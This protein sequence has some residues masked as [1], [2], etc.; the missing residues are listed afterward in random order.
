MGGRKGLYIVGFFVGFLISTSSFTM[1]L[2]EKYADVKVGDWVKLEI[3][4]G[5]TQLIF[6]ADRDEKSVTVEVKEYD[7]GFIVSWRQLVIDTDEKTTVLIREKDPVMGRVLERE[8]F[9]DEGEDEVLRAEFVEKGTEKLRQ[10]IQ[11]PSEDGK[12]L[13]EK[14]MTFNCVVY[15]TIIEKRFIEMWY[16]EEIP[17]YPVKVNIP[18]LNTTIWLRRYG[19][20]M[21][22]RFLPPEEESKAE[23]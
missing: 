14:R 9:E 2:V 3:S 6:V 8:P 10:T 13:V 11:F 23:D 18:G 20:D 16:S 1:T 21:K 12:E 5:T 15:K 7:R 22:S 19:S 4:N 17:L